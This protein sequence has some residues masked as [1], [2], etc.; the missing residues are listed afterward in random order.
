MPPPPLEARSSA[1]EGDRPM[2]R[3]GLGNEVHGLRDHR[4][5]EDA[6]SIHWRTSARAGRLI[7]VERE[8]ERRRRGGGG[9]AP[10]TPSGGPPARAPA[11]PPPRFRRGLSARARP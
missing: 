9:V 10:R 8:Q 3:V 1:R 5:G 11:N 7:A 6:R 4:S 2:A